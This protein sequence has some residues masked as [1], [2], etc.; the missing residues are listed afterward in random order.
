[1]DI[2]FVVFLLAL[3]VGPVVFGMAR[4]WRARER[5]IRQV[6]DKRNNP[7]RIEALLP[8]LDKCVDI[9]IAEYGA[10]TFAGPQL[11]D[12]PEVPGHRRDY[13]QHLIT[14]AGERWQITPPPILISVVPHEDRR[15]AAGTFG[16]AS[17]DWLFNVVSDGTVEP[18]D[19]PAWRICID[20]A[21]FNDDLAVATIVA[22]EFAH[23][24]LARDN[25]TL[26]DAGEDEVL[27][28]VAA[29]LAGFGQLMLRVQNRVERRYVAKGGLSYTI[30]GPGYLWPQELVHVLWRHGKLNTNAAA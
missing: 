16:P 1:V 18:S 30:G 24:V 10:D 9:L 14:L 2:Q 17:A 25:I 19:E 6:L 23:G 3:I 8:L 27:T 22:H 7:K 21:Y 28:D 11:A 29:A 26:N 12:V 13:I 15:Q 5:S 20:P 4:Q